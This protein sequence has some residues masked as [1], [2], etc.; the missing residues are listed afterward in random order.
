MIS[1]I[2]QFPHLISLGTHEDSREA[3]QTVVVGGWLVWNVLGPVHGVPP[4]AEELLDEVAF[5][6]VAAVESG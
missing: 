1:Q 3:I 5:G 2:F 6:A 4:S